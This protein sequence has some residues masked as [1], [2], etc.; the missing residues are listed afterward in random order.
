MHASENCQRIIMHFEGLRLQSY[1]CPA[2]KPTIG[3]GSTRGVEL[4]MTI[5]PEEALSRLKIDLQGVEMFLLSRVRVPLLQREFDALASWVFN[6]KREPVITSTLLRLLNEG[7]KALA[8]EE[9]PRWKF[10]TVDG[11]PVVQLGLVRRRLCERHLFLT[12][13][14]RFYWE[15]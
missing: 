10:A 1:L 13:E 2:G 6:C 12:G 3:W 11:K 14:V 9:F 4:G 8:A 15:D 5:S 7:Q